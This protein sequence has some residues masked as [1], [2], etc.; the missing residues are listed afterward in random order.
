MARITPE[1]VKAAQ[2]AERRREAESVAQREAKERSRQR[3]LSH[4]K[5][6]NR[7]QRE[8]YD[9][10]RGR[11][12]LSELISRQPALA[13]ILEHA[14]PDVLSRIHRTVTLPKVGAWL[15]DARVDAE[16]ARDDDGGELTPRQRAGEF[17]R[18]FV[19]DD[20]ARQREA[21]RSDFDRAFDADPTL[22]GLFPADSQEREHLRRVI[23]IGEAGMTDD[24]I[25]T[26]QRDDVTAIADA[27]EF[28]AVREQ[29]DEAAAGDD[30]ESSDAE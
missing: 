15:A 4:I 29:P 24:E 9:D 27:T 3:V 2:A 20:E 14:P 13:R 21:A 10:A 5:E 7:V 18:E 12:S 26:L 25:K 30:G 17:Y 28:T 16:L 19:A 8:S 22:R 6:L 1:I 11:P 23:A